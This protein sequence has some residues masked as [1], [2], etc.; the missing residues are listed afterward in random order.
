M[1]ICHFPLKKVGF[2][3]HVPGV[4]G[5][6]VV[7]STKNGSGEREKQGISTEYAGRA[8]SA[9]CRR[10]RQVPDGWPGVSPAGTGG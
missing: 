7:K 5:G 3:R 2:Y 8:G 1:T 6:E 10:S 9:D 4:P